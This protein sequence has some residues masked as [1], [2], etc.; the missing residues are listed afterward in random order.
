MKAFKTIKSCSK[1]SVVEDE[2]IS[3]E[4]GSIDSALWSSVLTKSGQ[5]VSIVKTDSNGSFHDESKFSGAHSLVIKFNFHLCK[6][7]KASDCGVVEPNLVTVD[8]IESGE[9]K[10]FKNFNEFNE[11]VYAGRILLLGLKQDGT[12][13]GFGFEGRPSHSIR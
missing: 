9:T 4:D 13:R 3:N 6:N 7:D 5:I 10:I 1:C 2:L 12:S 11:S 8:N